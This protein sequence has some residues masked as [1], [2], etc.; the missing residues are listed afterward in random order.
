MA[1]FEYNS[2]GNIVLHAF[3][4]TSVDSSVTGIERIRVVSEAI[5]G[6][7]L[8][9]N[10][11]TKRVFVCSTG[12]N[13]FVRFVKLPPVSGDEA[14]IRQVVKSEAED[15]VP[16]ALDEVSWD[17]QLIPSGEDGDEI[18]VMIVVMKNEITANLTGSVL[19]SGLKTELIGVSSVALLNAAKANNVGTDECV[20]L[21]D[22][23]DRC[24][25]LLFIDGDRFFS[26]SIPIAG[27][28]ITKQ[29]MKEFKISE[30]AAE[31][32]KRKHGFVALGAGYEDPE[33]EVA[34][35]V[36]K[37]IRNVL[38]RLHNDINQTRSVFKNQYKGN[39]PVALYLTGGSSLMNYTDRFFSEKLGVRV[40][41]FNPF[42]IVHL[43]PRIEPEK[44]QPI[45]HS[46]ATVVGIAL[47]LKD[48]CPIEVN[49]IPEQMKRSFE[50]A[51]RKKYLFAAMAVV[52]AMFVLMFVNA[53]R[54]FSV[55]EAQRVCNA[56][57]LDD[58]LA[59]DQKLDSL[60]EETAMKLGKIRQVEEL[61]DGR[62]VWGRAMTAITKDMPNSVTLTSIHPSFPAPKEAD[63]DNG[64]RSRR[65]R[66][67]VETTTSG[68]YS[69][70][71]VDT[72]LIKGVVIDASKDSISGVTQFKNNLDADKSF[73]PGSVKIITTTRNA[74]FK[75]LTTFEIELVL[76][77]PIVLKK[78]DVEND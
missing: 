58:I 70:S 44:L 18:E 34:A 39:A 50:L 40:E 61:R 54:K 72:L 5:K 12:Q 67:V 47:H 37:I 26:R 23:G 8:D 76:A 3:D 69:V 36:S 31:E 62:G 16:F 64:S 49:L 74:A 57:V 32:I 77:N 10:F 78:G 24:S 9:N 28:A 2:T 38:T 22:I 1:E 56:D 25:D 27:H 66:T 46:F 63:A 51:P 33:S 55:L 30:S 20:M 43:A 42:E 41:F 60:Y 6:M 68:I 13:A 11:T 73:T 52:I 4:W 53:E 7:L 45:A 17:Y 19:R 48:Q 29:I 75:N 14:K 35:V 21:L 15:K 65:S 71:K 59:L